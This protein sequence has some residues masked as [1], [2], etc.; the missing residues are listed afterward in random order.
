MFFQLFMSQSIKL[1]DMT[2]A[3]KHFVSLPTVANKERDLS[4]SASNRILLYALPIDERSARSST[5]ARRRRPISGRP[6]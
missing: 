5:L 6:I 4:Q 1:T 2:K 3:Q